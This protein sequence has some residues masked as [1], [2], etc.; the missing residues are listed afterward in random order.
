MNN[1]FVRVVALIMAGLM[2]LGIFVGVLNMLG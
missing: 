1:K 2:V